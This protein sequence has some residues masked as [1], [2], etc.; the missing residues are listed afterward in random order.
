MR[1]YN[2]PDG[3]SNMP[4][5][6]PLEPDVMEVD[7]KS[8]RPFEI[9]VATDASFESGP[10]RAKSI[11]SAEK[12]AFEAMKQRNTWKSPTGSPPQGRQQDDSAGSSQ[13]PWRTRPK[14]EPINMEDKF[15]EQKQ[16]E[17][18]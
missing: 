10:G 7:E 8:S 11:A 13:P 15:W 6:P 2:T 12:L 3:P 14:D 4:P 1:V 9:T 5:M 17:D 16:D 18:R